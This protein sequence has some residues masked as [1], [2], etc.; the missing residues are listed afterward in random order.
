MILET[1]GEDKFD[2]SQEFVQ[3][4]VFAALDLAPYSA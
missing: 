3:V 1:V 4:L 2:V